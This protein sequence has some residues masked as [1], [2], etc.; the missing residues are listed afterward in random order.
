MRTLMV[1]GLLAG[2]A[3]AEVPETQEGVQPEDKQEIGFVPLLG[4]STD[5]GYG[6]GALGTVALINPYYLPNKWNLQFGGFFAT[7]GSPLSPSYEDAFIQFEMP[8]L[9]DDTIDLR[10][11]PSF[12]RETVLH[13]FGLGN[14][15]PNPATL[16]TARDNYSRIHPQLAVT[17]LW[18]FR[19]P[20]ALLV[21][22][23]LTYNQLAADPTSTIVRDTATADPNLFRAHSV[24]R[25]E[26]ALS[27]DTRDH[28]ISPR[29]GQYHQIEARYSPR[30]GSALPYRYE[31]FN[32]TSRFYQTLIPRYLILAVRGVFDLQLGDVP[33]YELTRFEDTSAIGGAL[34]VRGVPAYQFYGRVKAFGNF[35][36]RSEPFHF[37]LRGKRYILG[38]ATFIDAGRLWTDITKANP[39]LDGTGL[40]IHYGVGGGVRIQQG[41]TFLVRADVAWSPDARPVGAYLLADQAF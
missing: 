11:R 37:A 1:M 5:V 33:T 10:I 4:G 35:E 26:S 22:A 27:Y 20:W 13:Y 32:A 12:T 23:V 17:A 2:T 21:G 15:A 24:L 31:Q 3:L 16:D 36:L 40:G 38:F 19:E 14:N 7:K 41:Q 34:G 29:Q 8:R 9:L 39:A 25:L 6:I 30:I 18:T 28:P